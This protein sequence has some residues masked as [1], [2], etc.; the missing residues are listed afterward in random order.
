MR[1][2][3]RIVLTLL[4]LCV[5]KGAFAQDPR[6]A[7]QNP[8]DLAN[9]RPK[10]LVWTSVNLDAARKAGLKSSAKLLALARTVLGAPKGT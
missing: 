2:A 7:S 8:D 3:A 9:A 6:G 4:A 1:A 5:C 10:D